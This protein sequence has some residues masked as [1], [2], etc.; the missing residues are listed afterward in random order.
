MLPFTWM[1]TFNVIYSTTVDIAADLMIMAL[2]ITVLQSL[3]L[4][5]KKKVGLGIAFSLAII[6]ICVAVVRMTQVIQGKPVE[7]VGLAVW[8]AVE[9]ATAVIVGSLPPLKALLT[10]R[11]KKYHSST[12]R[13]PQR[14]GA[15]R[16]Q[17]AAMSS[18]GPNPTSRSAMVTE[19][20]PLDDLHRSNQMNGRIYVQKTYETHVELD[21]SSRDDDDE[22]AIVRAQT[23]A[24]AT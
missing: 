4:D 7:L 20:I 11:V 18:Y 21:N 2:P 3:Q 10:R 15:Q 13:T 8:G 23:K 22:A 14:Y 6:T 9:T 24:W 12:K 19:S 5:R 16:S 17:P 1:Q